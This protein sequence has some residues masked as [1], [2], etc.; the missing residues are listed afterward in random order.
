MKERP[1][2]IP[3]RT[4]I[5][6]D[7]RKCL[8]RMSC[9]EDMLRVTMNELRMFNFGFALDDRVYMERIFEVI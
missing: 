9:E 2:D 6:I 5:I 8:T 7:K 1:S 3:G 4:I